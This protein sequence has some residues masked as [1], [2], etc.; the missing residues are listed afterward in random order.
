M[1]C[2]LLLL[3]RG[4]PISYGCFLGERILMTG[5]L[6]QTESGNAAAKVFG[7]EKAVVPVK[8]SVRFLMDTVSISIVVAVWRLIMANS[9]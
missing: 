3:I 6:V 9:L 2:V 8:D 4:E 1:G 5:R 7:M